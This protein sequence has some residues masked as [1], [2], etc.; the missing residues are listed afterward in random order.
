MS[1]TD[2][3]IPIYTWSDH[4]GLRT[5]FWAVRTVKKSTS[6]FSGTHVFWENSTYSYSLY[7]K[8]LSLYMCGWLQGEIPAGWRAFSNSIVQMFSISGFDNRYN[9]NYLHVYVHHFLLVHACRD[10]QLQHSYISEYE[11]LSSVHAE[12]DDLV[13]ALS[14]LVTAGSPIQVNLSPIIITCDA[15]TMARLSWKQLMFQD[16]TE[17]KDIWMLADS[18]YRLVCLEQLLLFYK[19]F[20]PAKYRARKAPRNFVQCVIH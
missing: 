1:D 7:L 9:M 15:D 19:L 5:N 18:P 6:L 17:T 3:E 10:H 20:Y 8:C 11:Q 2:N 12:I 14:S 13:N 4:M 16:N